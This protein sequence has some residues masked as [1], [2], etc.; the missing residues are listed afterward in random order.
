[1]CD[2]SVSCKRLEIMEAGRM[3]K[4]KPQTG[5]IPQA[6]S[7]EEHFLDLWE[8]N[9]RLTAAKMQRNKPSTAND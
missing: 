8:E 9:I 7:P 6:K 1:M 3:K 5:S 2:K 4:E